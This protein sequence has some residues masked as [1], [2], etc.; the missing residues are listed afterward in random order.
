MCLLNKSSLQVENKRQ[1]WCGFEIYFCTLKSC[2]SGTYSSRIPVYPEKK[3]KKKIVSF[4]GETQYKQLAIEPLR[5]PV[6]VAMTVRRSGDKDYYRS[7][8]YQSDD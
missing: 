3:Q 5:V 1:F 8:T 7:L 4:H 2:L 6:L